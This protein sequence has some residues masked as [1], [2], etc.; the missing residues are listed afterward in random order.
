MTLLQ[1]L[2]CH[3]LLGSAWGLALPFWFVL[4]WSAWIDGWTGRVPN[5]ILRR[6]LGWGLLLL[7]L[8]L[9]R[10][11]PDF[12][13]WP[14]DAGWRATVLAELVHLIGAAALYGLVWLLN[15][16]WRLWRGHDAL[17]MGD[18]KW[19]ALAALA[20]GLIPVLWAW[21]LAAWFG[22]L[23]LLVVRRNLRARLYFAPF[24][25]IAL[26]MVKLS[27]LV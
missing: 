25:F 11:Y 27:G 14:P 3:P 12:F 6:G 17:G 13:G 20:F 21:A 7:G 9:L 23:W 1:N 26:L 24:L 19:S 22:L 18:A 15:G 4:G 2:A 16:V 5:A 10:P 8:G